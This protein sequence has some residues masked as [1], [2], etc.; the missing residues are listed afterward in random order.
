M[1]IQE[2]HLKR[3]T[4]LQEAPQYRTLCTTCI[5]P[6]F[7]CYCAQVN[8]FDSK[9]NFVVLIHPIEAK[10]RIATG[11][12]SHLTLNDSHL[13]Q[14]QDYTQDR[15]VNNLINDSE[16]HSVILYPG[17]QSKNVS[18][19]N[20]E[21]KAALFPTDK[22]LRIFVID[23]TWA[24][25]RKMVRLSENLKQIPRICF[26]PAKPSNFRVRKQPGAECY[27]TIEAIHHT[28]ELLGDSQGFNT[29]TREHDHLLNVFDY[30]VERQLEF[31][32]ESNANPKASTYRREAQKKSA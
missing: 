15:Y 28:I 8:T 24:T 11:R 21:E 22:K 25:A 30:M 5:Q 29:S 9:I 26:T 2:Y 13:I 4:L 27:S 23:G 1:N 17:H 20:R 6:Q 14:G 19:L 12:M 10:R 18:P 3:A 7:G 32:R 31:I 16:Y